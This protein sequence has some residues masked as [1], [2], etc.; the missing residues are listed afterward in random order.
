MSIQLAQC[1]PATL[2]YAFSYVVTVIDKLS[3]IHNEVSGLNGLIK[4][5]LQFCRFLIEDYKLISVVKL[6]KIV[7]D[8]I[9]LFNN[10]LPFSSTI[11]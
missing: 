5:L 3:G 2:K 7:I 10:S 11:D 4:Y 6:I 8:V 9:Y 1:I